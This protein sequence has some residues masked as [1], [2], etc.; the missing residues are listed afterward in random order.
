MEIFHLP[1]LGNFIHLEDNTST[2]DLLLVPS[3]GEK[4]RS[5]ESIY[6]FNSHIWRKSQDFMDTVRCELITYVE[7]K[8]RANDYDIP[9]DDEPDNNDIGTCIF[10]FVDLLMYG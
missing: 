2:V 7:Y 6:D 3:C 4:T 10:Y 1:F 8:N 9:D 5:G